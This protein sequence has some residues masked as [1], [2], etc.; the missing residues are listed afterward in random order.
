MGLDSLPCWG[1]L[2]RVWGLCRSFAFSV[3]PIHPNVSQPW[4]LCAAIEAQKKLHRPSAVR[5]SINWLPQILP[6]ANC[7]ADTS[8]TT[9]RT[10]GFRWDC[11]VFW[12][13]PWPTRQPLLGHRLPSFGMPNPIIICRMA[14]KAVHIRAVSKFIDKIK[15]TPFLLQKKGV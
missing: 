2:F 14:T 11:G 10:R 4:S 1:L 9:A 6:R 15:Q 12:K 8:G 13:R 7:V 3:H 5:V